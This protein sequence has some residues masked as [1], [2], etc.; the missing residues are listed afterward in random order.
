VC[1]HGHS[2]NRLPWPYVPVWCIAVATNLGTPASE[3]I[4]IATETSSAGESA[5]PKSRIRVTLQTI[6]RA[7]IT[8]GVVFVLPLWIAYL[9]VKF[10]FEA[11]RDASL[12]VVEA[13]LGSDLGKTLV[14][15][16]GVTAKQLSSEGLSV[17]KPSYQW[18]IAIVA[19]LLTIVLLY[20]VGLF[21]AN[22]FGKRLV[23]GFERLL[24]RVPLVKTVYKASKQILEAFANEE[25]RDFRRVALIPYPSMEVRS[26]GFITAV[27]KDAETGEALCTCFLATTPNPTT[28][29][30]FVLRRADLIELDWTVEDTISI[31]MSGGALVPPEVPFLHGSG[32]KTPLPM[33]EKPTTP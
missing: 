7:R 3:T 14:E 19:V 15:K 8:A 11:M 29:Y 6:L 13:Y 5:R 1:C 20:L 22:F 30:V 18:G 31:I 9:L 12:W 28:G 2:R 16:L 21:T 33:P 4:T 25:S 27:T 10:L 32:T 24:D 17:L 26:L 23:K